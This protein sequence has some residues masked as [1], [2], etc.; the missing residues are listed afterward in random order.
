MYP[1]S[2][3]SFMR[4]AKPTPLTHAATPSHK[5]ASGHTL[6][7]D[8]W[9]ACAVRGLRHLPHARPVHGEKYCLLLDPA[10]VLSTSV[11]CL[12]ALERVFQFAIRLS[13]LA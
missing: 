12:A 10:A 13:W 6:T 3:W 9:H 11:R 1:S 2:S 7:A 4:C 8:G 5:G